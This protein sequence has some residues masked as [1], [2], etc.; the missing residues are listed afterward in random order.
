MIRSKPQTAFVPV[1]SVIPHRIRGLLTARRMV[2]CRSGMA[3]AVGAA[4]DGRG[5]RGPAYAPGIGFRGWGSRS[6]CNPALTP[7]SPGARWENG[8]AHDL[9]D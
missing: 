1:A 3:L 9:A 6:C 7:D 8:I 4:R 2:N 5:R